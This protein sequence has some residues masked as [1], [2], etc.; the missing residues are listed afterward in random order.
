MKN[1]KLL[2]EI[3]DPCNL[4]YCLLKEMMLQNSLSDRNL[5]QIKMIEKFKWDWSN[6][7]KKEYSWNEAGQRFAKEYGE[8][9][10]KFW[11]RSEYTHHVL[12]MYHALTRGK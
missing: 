3:C 10:S 1:R 4:E 6:S 9:Y 11:D 8:L 12:A 7:E 5:L 2:E